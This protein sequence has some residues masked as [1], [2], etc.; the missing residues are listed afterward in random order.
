MTNESAL[1]IKFEHYLRQF[2][3]K[4]YLHPNDQYRYSLLKTDRKAKF[5]KI[6]LIKNNAQ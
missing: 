4:G 3:G 5:A 1:R 2:R 6:D